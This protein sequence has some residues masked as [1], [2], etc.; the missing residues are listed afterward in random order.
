LHNIP[1]LKPFG[2]EGLSLTSRMV[3]LAKTR[4]NLMHSAIG[5]LRPQ[6]GAFEFRLVGYSK[7]MHTVQTWEFSLA[8]WP[9]LEKSLS[10]LVT[11]SIRFSQRLADTFR[12]LKV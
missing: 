9:K 5:S 1:L 4:N 2:D 11:D 7:D 6:D 12:Q 10:D 8:Q 3:P